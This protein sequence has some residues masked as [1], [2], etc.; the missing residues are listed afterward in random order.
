MGPSGTTSGSNYP[1]LS[2]E[3]SAATVRKL[4]EIVSLRHGETLSA[5]QRSAILT[6]V[7]GQLAAA[8]RLHRFS[9]GNQCEPIFTVD[10]GVPA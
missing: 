3:A 6:C 1:Q 9:L 7:A 5:A 10:A 4:A 8:E 2:A